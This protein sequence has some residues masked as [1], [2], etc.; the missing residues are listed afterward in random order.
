M[1]INKEK[2]QLVAL[3]QMN[4]THLEEVDLINSIYPLLNGITDSSMILSK[5]EDF[6]QHTINHFSNEEKLM[7]Q[8]DFFAYDCHKNAHQQA[9]EV[10]NSLIEN[11]KKD[12]LVA[13]LKHYFDTELIQWLNNHIA[14]MDTVTAAFLNEKI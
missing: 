3:E 6:R 9:L 10:I 4:N 13:P 8:Y 1:L 11:Y 14:T 12:S 5:L 2:L 7:Q